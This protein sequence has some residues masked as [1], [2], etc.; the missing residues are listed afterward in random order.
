MENPQGHIQARRLAFGFTALVIVAILAMESWQ[1]WKAHQQEFRRAEV[2]ATNVASAAA[3]HARDAVRQA[4][5]LLVGLIERVE[6]DGIDKLQVERMRGLMK[7]QQRYLPQ[8]HGLFIYD[9]DGNWLVT[10]KD[11]VPPAPTTPTAST[12]SITAN[13]QTTT[14]TSAR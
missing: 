1:V 13:T 11:H 14:C 7:R 8:L 5:A 6:W 12:S 9:K 3:Q 2:N 4:D 10:D